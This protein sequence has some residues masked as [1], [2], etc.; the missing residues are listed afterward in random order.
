MYS[1]LVPQHKTPPR[2]LTQTHDSLQISPSCVSMNERPLTTTYHLQTFLILYP[3]HLSQHSSQV[4]LSNSRK[5]RGKLNARGSW[6]V[7]G[8]LVLEKL[9]RGPKFLLEKMVPRTIF[10]GKIGPTLKILVPP[11]A[12]SQNGPTLKILVPP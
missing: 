8:I 9:V 12:S 3:V 6:F 11:E 7:T 2:N 1:F 10:S 4:R 5:K